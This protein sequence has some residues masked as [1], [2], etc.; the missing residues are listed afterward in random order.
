MN[1]TGVPQG[2]LG[3]FSFQLPS[4][5]QELSHAPTPNTSEEVLILREITFRNSTFGALKTFIRGH[6]RHT[7]ETLSNAAAVDMILRAYLPREIHPDAVKTMHKLSRPQTVAYLRTLPQEA[8]EEPL[9]PSAVAPQPAQ[10]IIQMDLRHR[11]FAAAVRA[12]GAATHV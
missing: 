2:H 6:K 9:A 1:P 10:R 11:P 12:K 4:P 5:M 7:G 8:L 3:V